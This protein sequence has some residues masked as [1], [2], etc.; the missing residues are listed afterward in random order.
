MSTSRQ[1]QPIE[2]TPKFPYDV[3]IAGQAKAPKPRFV[4]V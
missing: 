1:W 3:L 2:G 4:A